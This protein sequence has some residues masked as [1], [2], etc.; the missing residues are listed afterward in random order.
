MSHTNLINDC[1]TSLGEEDAM[2]RVSTDGLFVAFF[3]LLVSPS[4]ILIL[5]VDRE[6]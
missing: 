6:R 3:F 5:E 2:N 1:Y 4:G